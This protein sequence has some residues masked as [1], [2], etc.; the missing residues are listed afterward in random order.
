MLAPLLVPV[1]LAI[2]GGAHA[3]HQLERVDRALA[4]VNLAAPFSTERVEAIAGL[5]GSEEHLVRAYLRTPDRE[6]HALIAEAYLRL[7]DRPIN[8]EV[9]RRAQRRRGSLIRP[10]WFL[11]GLDAREALGFN[12][13]GRLF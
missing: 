12:M 9:T 6:R 10:L 1:A 13:Y 2:A 11:D 3:V 4:A 7:A 5:E 8:E